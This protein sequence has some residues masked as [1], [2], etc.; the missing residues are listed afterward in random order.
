MIHFFPIFSSQ[1]KW[2]ERNLIL[3]HYVYIDFPNLEMY[4]SRIWLDKLIISIPFGAPG[5]FTRMEIE[6][7]M[8]YFFL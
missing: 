1:T 4:S 7:L 5:N 3:Y 2:D 8:G 6:T